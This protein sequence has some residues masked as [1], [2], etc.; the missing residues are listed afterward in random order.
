V[1]KSGKSYGRTKSLTLSKG[2]KAGAASD[3]V[4]ACQRIEASRRLVQTFPGDGAT[5]QRRWGVQWGGGE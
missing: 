4:L 5:A 2:L 1:I 3:A